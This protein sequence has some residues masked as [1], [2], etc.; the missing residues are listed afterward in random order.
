MQKLAHG[1]QT[2]TEYG[3]RTTREDIQRYLHSTKGTLFNAINNVEIYINKRNFK[4][5]K[6]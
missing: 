3:Q 5:S 1:S 2:F 4:Q 6:P